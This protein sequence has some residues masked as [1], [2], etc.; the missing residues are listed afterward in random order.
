M[1]THYRLSI[2]I[3]LLFSVSFAQGFDLSFLKYSPVRNF[4]KQDW[5]LA[6]A[7]A[8]EVLEAD[9]VGK[10]ASWKNPDS[11]NSGVLKTT[12]SFEKRGTLCKTLRIINRSRSLEGKALYHFCKQSD[13]T[14]K[15]DANPA[16]R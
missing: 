16:S 7:A 3:V 14:W 13:G 4:T 5:N 11:G 9:E 8:R 10:T 2:A 12:K 15:R 1:N 6:K